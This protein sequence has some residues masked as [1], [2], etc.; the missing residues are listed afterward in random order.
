MRDRLS[1]RGP[2]GAKSWQRQ[3]S[4]LA[5]GLG[6]RRLKVVDLRDVADQPMVSADGTKVICFNGEIYNYVELRRELMA[7]GRSFRTRSDT[8][9]LLQAYEEWGERALPRLNGMFAFVIWDEARNEA[10][11]VRD[12]FGEKPLF[13][14]TAKD[15]ALLFA[16]EMKGLFA[17]PALS[18]AIDESVADEVLGGM[19]TYGRPE[20]LF[21]GV[22]Q[23][24][25]AHF[26]RITGAGEAQKPRPYW[27]PAC[28][29]ENPV[30]VTKETRERFFSLLQGAVRNRLRCDV[31]GTAALSGGLDS[32]S[33]V[34]LIAGM[35]SPGFRLEQT[36]SVQ[37][38]DSP[39]VDESNHQR[40]VSAFTGIAAAAVTPSPSDLISVLRRLHWHHE[41]VVGG[42]S[43]FAEWCVMRWAN[44]NGYKVIIDG[45]GADEILAGYKVYWD[46]YQFDT[47]TRGEQLRRLWNIYHMRRRLRAQAHRNPG[48]SRR[49]NAPVHLDREALSGYWETWAKPMA[50]S[51]SWPGAPQLRKGHVLRYALGA[52]LM[53][54]SLPSNLYAGDRNAM[55]HGVE[56][57]YP[58][59][60]Y[61]LVDFCMSLADDAFIRHGWQKWL[62][63]DAMRNRLPHAVVWRPDK[64][65]Y[66]VPQHRWIT[67][68]LKE[69]I[70][71]RAFDERIRHFRYFNVE[72]MNAYWQAHCAGEADYSG[73]LWRAAS[74]S[75]C[76]DM[77]DAG[78]WRHGL[79]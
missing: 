69:W 33:L 40:A 24:P 23:F 62:L 6:H 26:M 70:L 37:F 51:Y 68:E 28:D 21:R 2:D 59:L 29:P 64:V 8:E 10:I 79:Q 18:P 75:E 49:L 66:E 43:M 14:A 20:T 39:E 12:R 5:V 72:R 31:R 11:V 57:R 58:Y 38:P 25:A 1:H 36:I 22:R 42:P 7:S 52:H 44:Q 48:A 61:D 78:V 30:V 73:D 15:G 9:V 47:H 76:I 32:S 4:R 63:R 41:G 34:A 60:D 17:H 27:S 53:S 19:L 56:A 3:Y 16:S 74:L 45:Q 54:I 50:A 71:E 77:I 46:A 65:G 67:A 13:F 55:A 35:E